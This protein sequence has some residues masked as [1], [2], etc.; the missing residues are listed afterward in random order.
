MSQMPVKWVTKETRFYPAVV[1]RAN[2]IPVI[3]LS[4]LREVVEALEDMISLAGG[5]NDDDAWFGERRDANARIQ[6]AQRLLAS[7]GEK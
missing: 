6:K 2:H 1:D 4:A 3:P 5:L 7:L